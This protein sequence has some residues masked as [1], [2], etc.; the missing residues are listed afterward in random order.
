MSEIIWFLSFSDWLIPL[1]IM[2]SRSQQGD[3][4]KG[5]AWE[6]VEER[7]RGINGDGRRLDLGW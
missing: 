1:S 7:I 2:L 4:Q 6:E 3:Y 5:K